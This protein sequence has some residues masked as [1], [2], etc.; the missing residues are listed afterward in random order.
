MA[1]PR[2][3]DQAFQR[4]MLS[5]VESGRALRYEGA[6]MLPRIDALMIFYT[7]GRLN[8]GQIAAMRHGVAKAYSIHPV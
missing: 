8:T 5:I 2:H 6:F 7:P 4:L 1:G 3:M